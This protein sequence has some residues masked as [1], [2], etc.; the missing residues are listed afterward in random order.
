MKPSEGYEQ[1]D[2][3]ARGAMTGIAGNG[4]VE[5][6]S[7]GGHLV[8]VAESVTDCSSHLSCDL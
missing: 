1:M 7:S 4:E 6:T 2:A 8:L 3:A 5:V